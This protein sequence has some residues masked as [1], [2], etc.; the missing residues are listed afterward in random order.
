[1]GIQYLK[2]FY[3]N[4]KTH[5]Y[6]YPWRLV[7]SGCKCI[8]INYLMNTR[9]NYRFFVDSFAGSV[10]RILCNNFM[11]ACLW[12]FN[13]IKFCKLNILTSHA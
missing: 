9:E 7:F 3:A 4:L 11:F 1:M 12:L 10:S 13:S 8:K 5:A 2:Q 6:F